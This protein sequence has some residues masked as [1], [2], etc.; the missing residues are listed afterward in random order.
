[1][2]STNVINN[3]QTSC[4]LFDVKHSIFVTVGRETIYK[5]NSELVSNRV[6][7]VDR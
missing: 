5:K 3:H 7:Y 2:K 6:W 1:M 4:K